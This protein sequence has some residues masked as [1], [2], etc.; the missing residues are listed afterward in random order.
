[1]CQ[2]REIVKPIFETG[3]SWLIRGGL[4]RPTAWPTGGIHEISADGQMLAMFFRDDILSNKI[5]FRQLDATCSLTIGGN[6]K[7]PVRISI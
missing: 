5:F 1:M 3:H 2:P 6:C 4:A 7:V